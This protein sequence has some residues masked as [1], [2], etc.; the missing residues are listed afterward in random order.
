[1]FV[2]VVCQVCGSHSRYLPSYNP[3]P[4]LG[5]RSKL[6]MMMMVWIFTGISNPL[7]LEKKQQA[8]KS[9]LSWRANFC[10][11]TLSYLKTNTGAI[12][13]IYKGPSECSHVLVTYIARKVRAVHWINFLSELG[14]LCMLVF[15]QASRAI[16]QRNSSVQIW[17][18]RD[19]STRCEWS[20]LFLR[21]Y[22]DCCLRFAIQFLY[23]ASAANNSNCLIRGRSCF[24]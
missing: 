21:M 12:A 18:V 23:F 15:T 13:F 9:K 16:C 20:E 17:E 22:G 5:R 1:M 14:A 2:V 11:R 8:H 7:I 4:S 6:I 24:V 10:T 19:E 3:R